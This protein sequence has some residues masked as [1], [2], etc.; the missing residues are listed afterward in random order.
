MGCGCGWKK[1]NKINNQQQ[2]QNNLNTTKKIIPFQNKNN[3]N[4][5]MYTQYQNRLRSINALPK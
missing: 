1:T 3:H 4:Y 5:Q 2:Q